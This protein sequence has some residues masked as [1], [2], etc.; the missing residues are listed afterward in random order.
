MKR[1]MVIV[2]AFIVV[3]G[4]MFLDNY[5]GRETTTKP[6]MWVRIENPPIQNGNVAFEKGDDCIIRGGD[7]TVINERGNEVAVRYTIECT[8]YGAGCPSGVVFLTTK[9]GFAAMKAELAK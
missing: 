7:L 2:S 9:K 4:L 5:H 3:V 8:S 6:E 1:N